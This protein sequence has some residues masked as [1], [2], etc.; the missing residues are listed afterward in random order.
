MQTPFIRKS[1]LVHALAKSAPKSAD[2]E[3]D[4]LVLL[5]GAL[6]GLWAPLAPAD[7]VGRIGIG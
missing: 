2:E 3:H 6:K 4:G 1:R 7:E 5:A